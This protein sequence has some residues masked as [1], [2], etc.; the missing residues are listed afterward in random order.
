MKLYEPILTDDEVRIIH[1]VYRLVGPSRALVKLLKMLPGQEWST[2]GD[3]YH[4]P[5]WRGYR[6]RKRGNAVLWHDLPR[7]WV[8]NDILKD[9][10]GC[11][12]I[13]S[14]YLERHYGKVSW[15]PHYD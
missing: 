7:G 14:W 3:E 2:F 5:S 9:L 6:L 13:L 12:M 8:G 11:D 10:T 4:A 1:T 15:L